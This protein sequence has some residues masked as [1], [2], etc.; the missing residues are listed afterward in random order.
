MKQ[1]LYV[2]QQYLR[3][4]AVGLESPPERPLTSSWSRSLRSLGHS[5]LVLGLLPQTSPSVK[6]PSTRCYTATETFFSTGI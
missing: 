2:N 4:S 5:D 3:V 6:C 1:K